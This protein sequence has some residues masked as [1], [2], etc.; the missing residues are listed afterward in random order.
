VTVRFTGSSFASKVQLSRETVVATF[1]AKFLW[2][3]A[4]SAY[5]IEGSPLADGAGESI[6]HR[7]SHRPG[8][9]A[10]GMNGDTA[11]DH[12]RRYADDV[13]LM[14]EL[15]LNSY[16]FS[17]SWSRVLP[18]GI[19]RINQAGLDFY[20]RLTDTLLE[21]RI[22]PML[23]LYHWDLPQML[24]E[25]GGWANPQSPDWFAEYAQLM[26]RTLADRVRFWTTINEPWVIV[27]QGYVEGR[28][29][30][31]RRNWAEAATVSKNLL[32]AHAAAVAAYRSIGKHD[33]G[34]VLNLVPIFP[35][36]ETHDDHKA[37]NRLDAYFNRQFLDPLVLGTVPS[38]L[39]EMFGP[40]W[41]EWTAEELRRIRQP[42]DYV[43]VNYYLRLVV[44]D[45]ARGGPA[46]A[47]AVAQPN[48]PYTAMGWEV[49]PEGLTEILGWVKRRYGDLPLYITENGA[50][51]DDVLK[52]N[53]AVHDTQR[54]QYLHDHLLAARRAIEAEVKLRGYFVWS[55][56]DNFEWQ[57][58]YSKRFGIVYV[59]FSSQRRIPKESARLYSNV[60]RSNG[61]ALDDGFDDH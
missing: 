41:P 11:C 30:P 43:G 26:F 39:G 6:W 19:G 53:H 57:C 49:Y 40:A 27:D 54:V 56:L 36:S 18:E 25:R 34:I 52:P 33:I 35:A 45:D 55:L 20:N 61:K 37:A 46:R 51:F 50:A 5:Q 29:A 47:R 21:H 60:I 3:A 10:D 38:E 28:H 58:G 16:R 7:F 2:G 24:E 59:D 23:T 17:T 44:R 13:A 8:T 32:L 15:G 14:R 12:Y 42:I 22:E 4:T 1:P 31:G 9:I 48:C